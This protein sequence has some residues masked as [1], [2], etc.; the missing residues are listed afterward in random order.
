MESSVLSLIRK[1]PLFF[2]E[3]VDIFLGKTGNFVTTNFEVYRKTSKKKK[4]GRERESGW[5]VELPIYPA[6]HSK[7]NKPKSFVLSIVDFC[8][9]L[10]SLEKMRFVVFFFEK[11]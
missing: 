11:C 2:V 7:K 10:F 3:Y 8:F 9:C 1:T 6:Q 5:V 4:N